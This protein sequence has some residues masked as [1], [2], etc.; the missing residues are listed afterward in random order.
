MATQ[1]Q[2]ALLSHTLPCHNILHAHA[3]GS[4]TRPQCAHASGFGPRSTGAASCDD[5]GGGRMAWEARMLH[6][7]ATRNVFTTSAERQWAG[8]PCTFKSQACSSRTRAQWARCEDTPMLC[9]CL[10]TV[11]HMC[12]LLWIVCE[13]LC[14][15]CHA[16][17]LRVVRLKA[18]AGRRSPGR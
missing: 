1:T 13:H 4:H 9:R 18:G 11:L 7:L 12:C 3:C 17:A 16:V 6:H 10:L 2:T 15:Q 8:R 5:T 14:Q